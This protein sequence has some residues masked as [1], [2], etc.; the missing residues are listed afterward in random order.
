MIGKYV[1]WMMPD[2]GKPLTPYGQTPMKTLKGIVTD[3]I[4]EVEYMTNE[5][6]HPNG[7]KIEL[8]QAF[9]VTKYLVQIVDS[10]LCR[11]LP[12]EIKSISD[13]ENELPS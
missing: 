12:S 9:P 7:G 8:K 4:I 11:L 1:S 2:Y 13:T 10:G 5:M 3:K 6:P